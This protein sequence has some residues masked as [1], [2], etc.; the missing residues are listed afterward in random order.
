M[1]AISKHR[2]GVIDTN[3]R[4]ENGYA[5]SIEPNHREVFGNLVYKKLLANNIQNIAVNFRTET[6]RFVPFA[7]EE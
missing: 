1:W 2:L 6:D 3:R 7:E 5:C 4:V